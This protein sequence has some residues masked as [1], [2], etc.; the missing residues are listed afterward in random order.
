MI[1]EPRAASP[2]ISAFVALCGRRRWTNR[3]AALTDMGTGNSQAARATLQRHALEL[4][5]ARMA[6]DPRAA[7][8]A[9]RG[10]RLILAF[11]RE[12]ARLAGSLA[13]APRARL[14]ALLRDGLEGEATLI[15][16]FHTL[17]IAA[18]QRA[19]G[20][21]VHFA[22]LADDSPHDLLIR[23]EGREAEVVCETVSAEEGRP[24]QRG[25]W[26]ALVDMVNPDL[27]T[28]LAAHPG[29]Y[30]LKMTLPEGLQ[31]PT[32]TAALHA[33][34]SAMLAAQ[35]RQ[36]ASGDAVM[37]LDPLILAGAQASLD[38]SLPST[39]RA[40]FGHEAH[41]A[42][43]GDRSGG[44][45]FVMAARA[46]QENAIA[47]AVTR[48]MAAAASARLTGRRPGI[49]AMFV[50]DL[51]RSEW[52]ALRETLELEGAARRFLTLPAAKP[53]LAISCSS[54]MEMFGLAPPDAAEGGELRFRNQAH[55]SA[56]DAAFLPAIASSV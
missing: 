12:A 8:S 41:L 40:S 32:R 45:V 27:R 23:R 5:L 20:F 11:A 42:V 25:D 3:V 37:K 26:C 21:E 46:G 9:S 44:S 10:E 47:S 38:P 15:P 54:R 39:L 51:Q 28:W 16:L 19:R 56:R 4:T 14:V 6:D 48:R 55:P 13:P 49:L 22:G 50:E 7:A 18:M 53:V 24:V 33:Q 31:G 1:A 43:T 34:I 52:R 29:R 36:N 17:R 30:L 2:D 35:K